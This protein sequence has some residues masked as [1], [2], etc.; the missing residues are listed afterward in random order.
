[1]PIL[2][3]RTRSGSALYFATTLTVL[4]ISPLSL[5]S[6]TNSFSL[7]LDLDESVGDQAVQSLDVMRVM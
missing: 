3:F 5:S 4:L 1:M 2:R 6:Q 7:F